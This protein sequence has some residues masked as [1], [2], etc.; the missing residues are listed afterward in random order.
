[1]PCRFD[2]LLMPS[3]FLLISSRMK[4]VIV[5]PSLTSPSSY[6]VFFLDVESFHP[7]C[8]LR[9]IR[10][11]GTIRLSSMQD[12]PIILI[13]G[14]EKC[15]KSSIVDVVFKR[16]SV[17]KT[18]FL[19]TTSSL[20][21]YTSDKNPLLEYNIW[22]LPSDMNEVRDVMKN[23]K[24]YIS[25]VAILIYVFSLEVRPSPLPLICRIRTA[26]STIFRMSRSTD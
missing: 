8:L 9:K 16:M 12:S 22:E 21:K 4:R 20:K 2:L 26:N 13:A 1:M 15:G 17:Y 18:F 5:F 11:M 6:L 14:Q 24:P 7:M 23:I 10:P 19:D 25:N 3:S